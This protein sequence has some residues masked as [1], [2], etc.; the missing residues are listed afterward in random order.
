[1]KLND[2]FKVQVI[3]SVKHY[4]TQ[5]IRQLIKG[6]NISVI[7]GPIGVGKSTIINM[8]MKRYSRYRKI[9]EVTVSEKIK[10]ELERFYKNEITSIEFQMIIENEY[11]NILAD[12][13]ETGHPNIP[14]LIDRSQIATE[15][16]SVYNKIPQEEI[17]KIKI[18]REYYETFLENAQIY[19]VQIPKW[20]MNYN[21]MKRNRFA[22]KTMSRKYCKGLPTPIKS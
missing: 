12:I 5:K 18:N 16:F 4:L 15:I 9:P 2:L 11:F 6:W 21:I 8:I 10:P 19:Y 1:M 20:L 7:E 14:I 22:E 17:A 13:L 3:D